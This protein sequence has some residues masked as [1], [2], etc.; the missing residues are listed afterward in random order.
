M[1]EREFATD[2]VSKLVKAGHVAYFAGGC[3]RDE[4]LGLQ[5]EDYDVATSARPEQVTALFRRTI[6][7]GASFGV[8]E[9][10]GPRDEHGHFLKVQVATFRSDGIYLD[11]RHP[12]QVVFSSPQEDATRRDFTINGMFLDP[13]T[14]TIYDYV[15]GQQD[16]ARGILRA[17]GRAEDRFS[18]DRLRMLRAVR[19]SARFRFPL[20]E[21]TLAAIQKMASGIQAISAERI[22]EE[23][24][25]MLT[26][27]NRAMAL[28]LIQHTHLLPYLFPEIDPQTWPET[29]QIARRLPRLCWPNDREVTVPLGF[30]ILLR[31]F[32]KKKIQAFCQRLKMTN[33]ELSRISWLVT[34][35]QALVD[36]AQQKKSQLYPIL[37]HEGISELLS[38]HEGLT[39]QPAEYALHVLR[40]TPREQLNP[41]VLL[42][43]DDLIQMGYKPGPLFKKWLEEL[44]AKQLDQ[45][46]H[47]REQAIAWL[48]SQTRGGGAKKS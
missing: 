41:P 47:N 15:G 6:E 27:P 17:I 18:E 25:K 14:G 45:E 1:T 32:D 8:V 19:M 44:R 13:L 23:L 29:I 5:P 46:I 34:H 16:L 30:A 10:I 48:E 38:L 24:R 35:Q 2:V 3:V 26:H 43:G 28:E 7:V 20:E 33:D 22:C 11:G 39:G 37:I 40:Q 21:Q 36:A 31:H 4:I 9:V 12:A 42:T